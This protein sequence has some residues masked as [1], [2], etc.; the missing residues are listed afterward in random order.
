MVQVAVVEQH[1]GDAPLLDTFQ[2][3][4]PGRKLTENATTIRG[5]GSGLFGNGPFCYLCDVLF[6]SSGLAYALL[7]SHGVSES[8]PS[9]GQVPIVCPSSHT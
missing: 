1:G 7:R 3:I 2:L 4:S 5:T 9:Q 8:T 6:T